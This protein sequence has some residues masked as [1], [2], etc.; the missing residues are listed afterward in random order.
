MSYR[1]ILNRRV[2]LKG[3][4]GGTV[5]IMA[6]CW[7][8][9][10]PANAATASALNDLSGGFLNPPDTARPWVYWF[11]I[12]GNISREGITADLEAMQRV[13]IGG[14]LIMEVD[15]SPQGQVA[16]GTENWKEM[17][18]FACIEANR[19][20]LEI[21]MNDGAGWT[22]SGGPWNTLKILCNIYIMLKS[23]WRWKTSITNCQNQM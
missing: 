6:G 17:F 11:W 5:G 21:N 14:V 16:F 9:L 19:L 20:G 22:G 18:R 8:N 13:G 3:V 12:N 10:S 1:K 7:I 23:R 2:F 4:V 15:G